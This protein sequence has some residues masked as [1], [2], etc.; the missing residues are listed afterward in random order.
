MMK[1][2]LLKTSLIALGSLTLG[3]SNSFAIINSSGQL[4]KSVEDR[5]IKS[6]I[7]KFKENSSL[8]NLSMQEFSNELSKKAMLDLKATKKLS[9]GAYVFD[10]QGK[11]FSLL[12][13]QQNINFNQ[14]LNIKLEQLSQD[15]AIEYADPNDYL[16]MQKTPNDSRYSEQWHYFTNKAGMNLPYAWDITTGSQEIVV[17]VVDTGIVKH[18]DLEGKILPGRNIVDDD[19]EFDDPTDHGGETSYHG[20]HV[21]GTIGALTNQNG[22]VAGVSWGAQILP[23]RVLDDEGSGTMSNILE[24]MRWAAGISHDRNPNPA[25]ILNLS[26]GGFGKCH[27][28]LQETIDEITDKGT[29]IVVAAGNSDMNAK[30]FKPANCNN[31]ITV[32]ASNNSG[33]KSFYSNFGEETLDIVAPGGDKRN[34]KSGGI[35]SLGAPGEFQFLQGTSMAAPHI[36]GLVALMLS[37]NPDLTTSQVIKYMQK[38]VKNDTMGVGLV[39]ASKVLE[40]LKNGIPIEEDAPEEDPIEDDPFDD[41][42]NDFFKVI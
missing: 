16:Y 34:D 12:S 19:N 28:S 4:F 5:P 1:N 27:A 17:G 40:M 6:I 33:K 31:V 2:N 25:K 26:L 42:F 37:I 23:V 39:D 8:K 15:P 7:V 9:N 22:V 38:N 13:K 18:E 29:I 10:I 21:A 3:I 41:I 35:L 30:Y 11:D 36:S 14:Q 20:T 32:G 24:G